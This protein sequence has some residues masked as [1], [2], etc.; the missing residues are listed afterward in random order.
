MDKRILTVQDISCVGQCS[1]TV[2]LPVISAFGLETAV[3]PTA[4]LSNH[5]YGYT[6][7]TFCDLTEQMPA[8]NERWAKECVDFDLLYTGYLGS[9]KQIEYI[10]TISRERMRAGAELVVDPVMADNGKLYTGFDL[11]F[12]EEMKGLVSVADVALPNITEACFLTGVE[13]VDGCTSKEYV[14]RLIDGLKALGAKKIVLTGVS[15]EADKLGVAVWDGS[16]IEYRFEQLIDK[17]FHGTGDLFAS[18]FVGA[19]AL[20]DGIA[21]A[22]HFAAKVVV[23][24]IKQTIGDDSHWYG[25]KFEKALPMI[26][27]RQ[28]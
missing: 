15:L 18:A 7:W 28:K 6:G 8:I 22:A 26:T 10:K 17:K 2:A 13:Y 4:V 1:L 20:G 9:A 25:V 16:R 12:V 11:S 24:A 3:L 21:D 23:S 5:T 27:A 19:Y 14:E